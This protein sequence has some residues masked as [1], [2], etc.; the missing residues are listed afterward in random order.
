LTFSDL[1]SGPFDE[2]WR[3][4]QEQGGKI[5]RIFAGNKLKEWETI[6]GKTQ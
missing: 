4:M 5:E 1:F 6:K 3:L 2:H